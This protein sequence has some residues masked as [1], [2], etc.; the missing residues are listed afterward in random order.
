M[1]R[2]PQAV[3]L[4][5]VAGPAW[6]QNRMI[7]PQ[8]QAMASQQN[9]ATP[10][11]EPEPEKPPEKKKPEPIPG[12]V[13]DVAPTPDTDVPENTQRVS[14]YNTH[15]QKESQAKDKTAFYKNAMPK[16]TTVDK[17]TELPGT[18]VSVSAT[19]TADIYVNVRV[20]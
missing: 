1:S 20:V 7:A 17:P 15:V 4:V 18:D 9:S 6:A 5:A 12:Q 14:E 19:S 8:Q 2:G 13:V 16:H 3:S 10:P 11:T